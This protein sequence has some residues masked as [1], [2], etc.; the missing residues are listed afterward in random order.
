MI[1]RGEVV[2]IET[3]EDGG[4]FTTV[5]AADLVDADPR[6]QGIV[7][8]STNTLPAMDDDGNYGRANIITSGQCPA[9]VLGPCSAGDSL[10]LAATSADKAQWSTTGKY[11][12]KG[13]GSFM[14]MDS[15]DT[16]SDG[17]PVMVWVKVVG[18]SQPAPDIITVVAMS[19]IN[20]A[21]T[22]VTSLD[23]VSLDD[24]DK[25]LLQGQTEASENGVWTVQH[26]PETEEIGFWDQ[27]QYWG[28]LVLL[29]TSHHNT[30]WT[31]DL[32]QDVYTYIQIGAEPQ[33]LEIIEIHDN[34]LVCQDTE[35]NEFKVARPALNRRDTTEGGDLS[36]GAT[37]GYRAVNG[38]TYTLT[39]SNSPLAHQSRTVTG[40]TIGGGGEPQIIG[41]VEY[42]AGDIV[43]CV[44]WHGTVQSDT[45]GTTPCTYLSLDARCWGTVP[46]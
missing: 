1:R 27:A 2:A 21:L 34:Y 5:K 24:G 41:P 6:A 31:L 10:C 7:L 36:A 42:I 18:P 30:L 15:V 22:G 19:V 37:V 3:F 17:K 8:G 26:D 23:G 38:V 40:G 46:S 9:L 35:S 4:E 28:V 32:S 45:S 33:Q 12:K 25:V 14:A 44:P 11:L 29:G 43:M 39:Y 20:Q 16:P 13:A